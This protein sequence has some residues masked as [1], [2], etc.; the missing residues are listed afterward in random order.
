MQI[1]QAV[2]RQFL[3]IN[4]SCMKLLWVSKSR[5]STMYL[6]PRRTSAIEL[7]RL[8]SYSGLKW[9]KFHLEVTPQKY[10]DPIG[11]TG[12]LKYF[13]L[14]AKIT[15]NA[16]QIYFFVFFWENQSGFGNPSKSLSIIVCAIF[17][18]MIKITVFSRHFSRKWEEKSYL[19]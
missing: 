7:K 9:K 1:R 19:F 2:F 14:H 3:G 10:K 8:I 11:K 13:Y 4:K 12:I 16:S 15:P 5:I 6:V 17:V 18:L